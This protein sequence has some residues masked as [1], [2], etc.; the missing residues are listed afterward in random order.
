MLNMGFQEDVERILESTPDRKQVALF[1][2][3]MPNAIR[4]LSKRYLDNPAEVTVKSERRTND[5]I[6]QRFLLI[7]HR[8]KMD[9]FTRILEVINYDAIIVF[10][11]TK[12][13]TEE[14]AQTL[15]D[16]GFSAA[17]ING[18]IAQAQRE[19]TVDQLKDGRLDIL[20]ATD[21][22]ARGVHVDGIELVVHV[23]PP[24]EHKA[25]L[26]RS[27]RTARAG[28]EGTV[29]TIAT[30]E[31][32]GEVK[33]L[34]RAA[35]IRPVTEAKAVVGAA[36]LQEVA[37]GERVFRDSDEL[38]V[39]TAPPQQGVSGGGRGARSGGR[40]GSGGSGGGR[41]AGRSGGRGGSGGSGRGGLGAGGSGGRGAA[42]GSGGRS[43]GRGASAGGSGRGGA[44]GPVR[45]TS[46]SSPRGDSAGRSGG[47][48]RGERGAGRP[49]R[50]RGE[51]SARPARG[52][53][54]SGR[55]PERSRPEGGSGRRAPRARRAR[56]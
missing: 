22:A 30:P 45:Y 5:N 36:V 6:T 54:G 13:E 3:T 34:M 46:E 43:G 8:A 26:H 25:Y 24:A 50:N 39:A 33:T 35:K 14:V 42:G 29:V 17:A 37:P 15:R 51:A 27:G 16:R 23:D 12:H 38:A 44:G 32:R 52:E 28:A 20:V 55:R 2:A 47:A 9:A 19:R 40:G 53:G 21:V 10:C 31:Q 4:R 1:S 49:P 56:G 7:P 48:P 18:D 41:G 11:R